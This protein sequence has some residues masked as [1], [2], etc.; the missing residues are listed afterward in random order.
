MRHMYPAK[1][2][3]TLNFILVDDQIDELVELNILDVPHDGRTAIIGCMLADL[4]RSRILAFHYLIKA[5]A[6][7]SFF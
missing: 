6:S 1:W 3:Y 7:G 5:Q 2:L 4:P